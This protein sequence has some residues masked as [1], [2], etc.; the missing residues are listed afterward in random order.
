MESTHLYGVVIWG[1]RRY[2]CFRGVIASVA[3][4]NGV[5]Y[6]NTMPHRV[7]AVNKAKFEFT[8]VPTTLPQPTGPR[9]VVRCTCK[10]HFENLLLALGVEY[11]S[12]RRQ[13]SSPP[14]DDIVS[15]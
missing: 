5:L 10:L 6:I 1:S 7:V 15:V 13:R 3:A 12:V 9:I 8:V 4:E 11:L 2:L 14:F